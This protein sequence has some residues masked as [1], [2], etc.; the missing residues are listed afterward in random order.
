MGPIQKTPNTQYIFDPQ[1]CTM[2]IYNTFWAGCAVI[3]SAPNHATVDLE[4]I[5]H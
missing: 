1:T 5:G 2:N 4:L 3:A